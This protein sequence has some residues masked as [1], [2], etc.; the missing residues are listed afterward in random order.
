M[1]FPA[2]V[3]LFVI[4]GVASAPEAHAQRGGSH[5][6]IYSH[7][8]LGERLDHHSSQAGMLGGAG[9]AL[10]TMAGVSLANPALWAD[11]NL[12]RLSISAHVEGLQAEDALGQTARLGG[13]QFAAVQVSLPLLE[14]RLGTTLSL[15]PFTRVNYFVTDEGVLT[16]T[17]LPQDSLHYRVNLEGE[18]GL[19]E[20]QLGFGWRVTRDLSLGLSARALFGALVN[21]QRTEYFGAEAFPETLVRRQTSLLGFGATAGAAYLA[22][23][24][25]RGRDQLHLGAAVSL[26]T[27]LSTRR[28]YTLG[29]S[30]DQ[31]TLQ[32]AAPGTTRLPLTLAAGLAYAPSP[33]W[34]FAIDARFE[35][36]TAFESDFAF[37]GYRP[38]AGDNILTDRLRLG[39]GVELIPSPMDRDAPLLARTAYRLGAYFDQGYVAPRGHHLSTIALTGGLS[40]PTIRPG[41]YL[42]LGLELGT[43]GTTQEGLVRDLFIRGTAT[44]NFGE[45]WFIRRQFI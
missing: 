26:P 38:G 44:I 17:G 40:L 3:A 6:S 25:L 34:M 29:Q 37:Q 13:G 23:N 39:G 22:S 16:E 18:G 42:D 12:V 28:I 31:D 9:M 14:N 10:P 43:R 1:R 41:T 2:T 35:P 4:A 27:H 24:V 7:F 20:A 32:A 5:G 11:L 33:R 36:W 30:L 19:H 21:R 45:R 15:R 8:I